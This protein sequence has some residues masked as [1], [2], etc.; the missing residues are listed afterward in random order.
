MWTGDPNIGVV[1]IVALVM[2]SLAAVPILVALLIFNNAKKK[3]EAEIIRLAIE[4]GQPVPEFPQKINKYSTFKASLIWIAIGL[5]LALMVLLEGNGDLD[6]ISLGI[7]PILIGA[8][9]LISWSLE[10]KEIEK[11]DEPS[12]RPSV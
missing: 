4:R 2:A 7:I 8:A 11:Q 10:K 5:G 6:G 3:R 9:L 12:I 1:M